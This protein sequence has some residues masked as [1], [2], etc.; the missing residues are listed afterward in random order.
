[1][2]KQLHILMIALGCIHLSCNSLV[3]VQKKG[4]YDQSIATD[5]SE[6]DGYKAVHI[7]KD[8]I[9]VSVWV[10]KETQCVTMKPET[11]NSCSGKGAMHIKWDKVTGG[12]A[13]IGCGFGWNNWVAK[14][15]IDIT[16][17]A[18]VQMKIKSAK[19]TFS[20]LPVAFAFEDYGGVQIYY[21]F[22]KNLASGLFNDSTWTT[23]T[24]PLNK[25]AFKNGDFNPE[26]V[27]Q[28]MIQLEG[29]GD[30]YLDN[31]Q[32]VKLETLNIQEIKS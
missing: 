9:D 6:I 14:N 16:D 17:V 30:I 11:V 7:F 22:Q 2:K 26:I 23:V 29:D 5:P 15:M 10:S 18:A 1:M 25:F 24:I 13:W 27:K 28:F 19:G 21:G 4:L 3:Q 8:E 20:N 31:I 32:I 12:C